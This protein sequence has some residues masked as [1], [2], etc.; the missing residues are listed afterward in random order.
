MLQ[1]VKEFGGKMPRT[2]ESLLK[3]LPGVGRYTAG[4]IA[5]IAYGQVSGEGYSKGNHKGL[6]KIVTLQ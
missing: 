5:S 2:T 1:V 3:H 4:A 6:C